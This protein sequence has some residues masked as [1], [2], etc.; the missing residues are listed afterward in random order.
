MA[1]AIR[2]GGAGVGAFYVRTS[3]GT[4]LAEGYKTRLFD[5]VEHVL[6]HALRADV[7][8]IRA[9]LADALGNLVYD[10]TARN[11]NPD[12]AT[13]A[14]LVIVQVDELVEVGQLDPEVIVTP[15]VL[16]DQ[17]VLSP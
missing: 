3:S 14:N 1:E 8:L 2:A 13:A 15:H 17:I 10:K 9:L 4:Q 7:A 6:Q 16:I 11:F 5:G 12:M